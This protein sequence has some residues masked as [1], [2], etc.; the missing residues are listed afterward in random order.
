MKWQT[1]TGRWHGSEGICKALKLR[2]GRFHVMQLN[3]K[4]MSDIKGK[5][6]YCWIT[7]STAMSSLLA[8]HSLQI[9]Q[10]THSWLQIS[11]WANR[12]QSFQFG[13]AEN[14]FLFVPQSNAGGE[15]S[16]FLSLPLYDVRHTDGGILIDTHHALC[17]PVRDP[18]AE[19]TP[20]LLSPDNGDQVRR[21]HEQ[22]RHWG[23]ERGLCQLLCS[24]NIA[25]QPIYSA[26]LTAMEDTLFGCPTW[27]TQLAVK[28]GEE[29]QR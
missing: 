17:N 7:S 13:S 16:R 18:D 19:T 20:G 5:Q 24:N 21:G 9:Y 2:L 8:I 26:I 3:R 27:G 25:S 28:E 1:G 29:Q 4:T 15:G 14:A 23:E 11:N 6:N 10:L 22:L 12:T